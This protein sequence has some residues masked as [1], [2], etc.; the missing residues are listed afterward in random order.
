MSHRFPLPAVAV[1]MLAVLAGASAPTPLYPVYRAEWGFSALTLTVIFAVYVL[2]LLA[3]LLCTGLLSDHIGRRAVVIGSL[4]ILAAAMA[5]FI[6]AQGVPELLVARILQGI[7]A[8]TLTGTLTAMIIE[9]SPS[10]LIGAKVSGV[11]PPIGLAAG[12]LLSGG[13]VEYAPW[14]KE[15]IYI[16]LGAAY[17]IAVG[18]IFATK[19]TG[20]MYGVDGPGHA[21]SL[22][23]PRLALPDYLRG[24]FLIASPVLFVTW[25]VGGLFLSLGSTV[26]GQVLGVS[27]HAVAGV[28]VAT[29]FGFAA[30]ATLVLGQR[31]L[32]TRARI[33]TIALAAGVA[34]FLAGTLSEN[35]AT[36]VG[37]AALAG[38]GF[39]S[40]F[41]AAATSIAM[42]VSPADRGRVFSTM[43]VIA[44]SGFSIPA[45]VAGLANNY[46]SLKPV[47]T[48]YVILVLILLLLAEVLRARISSRAQAAAP[49]AATS[50]A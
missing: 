27:N 48:G 14:P 35:F 20:P 33:G 24:T 5:I 8:G 42:A 25:A 37:G 29:L 47:V 39:G 43:F 17:L 30:A 12:A 49:L 6:A 7:A 18:L 45:V 11:M 15:L 36:Y 21:L 19:E 41:G 16:L 46:I 40:G 34:L 13:L 10:P 4:L 44:Y 38:V 2:A 23:R 31:S 26:T 32:A 28:V 9:H 50:A 1:T 22:L 3:T